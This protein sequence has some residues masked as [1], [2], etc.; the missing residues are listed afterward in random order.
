MKRNVLGVIGGVGPLS[1]AYFMEV[2]IDMTAAETDQQHIDMIVLN[3]TEIPDRTEYILDHTKPNPV[4]LMKKDAQKLEKWGADV[5]VTPCNTAHYFYNELAGAVKVPFLNM[6]DETA[7]MLSLLG[8]K[9]VGI[10]ATNGTVHTKLFQNALTNHN[11][12]PI[13]PSDENQKIIMDIIYDD[14]KAGKPVNRKKWNTIVD[15]METANCDRIILGCTELSI[16]K[17]DF[18]LNSYYVD[19]LEVLAEKAIEACG[20]SVKK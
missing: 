5:I 17:K 20:K 14:I 13:L 2:V 6:I 10:L 1:T 11:I 16:L 4:L 12:L 19:A 3:H 9:R 15:E 18:S 8:A 7:Q